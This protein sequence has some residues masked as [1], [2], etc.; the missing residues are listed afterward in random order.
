M[1]LTKNLC[2]QNLTSIK[3]LH[4]IVMIKCF[5]RIIYT[6]NEK[7][8]KCLKFRNQQ[9]KY[10]AL[11]TG[12]GITICRLS[13]SNW[14]NRKE[15]GSK[16]YRTGQYFKRSIPSFALEPDHL[17]LISPDKYLSKLFLKTLNASM[18]LIRFFCSFTWVFLAA[19]RPI[20]SYKENRVPF[21]QVPFRYVGIYY[22]LLHAKHYFFRRLWFL[23]LQ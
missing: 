9:S 11:L 13:K 8:F 4:S 14:F 15:I 18:L 2:R 12:L 6:C 5:R 21:F 17:Y 16:E 3:G 19:L 1:L 20:T 7:R 10:F 23:D 22:I